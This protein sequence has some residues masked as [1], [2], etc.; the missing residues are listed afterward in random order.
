MKR[1]KNK[2][3]TSLVLLI[4][5]VLGTMPALQAFQ[6]EQSCFMETQSACNCCCSMEESKVDVNLESLNDRC[7]CEMSKQ[8]PATEV[9]YVAQI[10]TIDQVDQIINN[11][12]VN[13]QFEYSC[14]I[15][16]NLDYD[17]LPQIHAPPLYIINSSF[18]I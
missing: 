16:T 8:K 14:G 9:P 12:T 18:L 10:F 15:K 3:K 5:L 11:N 13:I 6:L 4:V 2:S 7:C 17:L 1:F